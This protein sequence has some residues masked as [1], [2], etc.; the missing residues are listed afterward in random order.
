LA[1]GKQ[2]FIAE[3]HLFP[4]MGDRGGHPNHV[5]E[6]RFRVIFCKSSSK[7]YC[8]GQFTATI[9]HALTEV[10]GNVRGKKEGV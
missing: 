6:R 8:K 2:S 10:L 3:K 5:T 9:G 7:K 1:N 4:D